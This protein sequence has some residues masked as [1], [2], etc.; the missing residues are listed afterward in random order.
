MIEK[1]K[2]LTLGYT[3]LAVLMAQKEHM[4]PSILYQCVLKASKDP[5]GFIFVEIVSYWE[6]HQNSIRL[7]VMSVTISLNDWMD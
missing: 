7:Y 5:Q 4:K 1:E 2:V 6:P 3:V